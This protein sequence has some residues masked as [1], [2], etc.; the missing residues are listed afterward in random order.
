MLMDADLIKRVE[1]ITLT[2]YEPY[3]TKNENTK[4][5]INDNVIGMIEDLLLEIDRLDEQ[6]ENMREFYEEHY[7]YV[8]EPDPDVRR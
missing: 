2:D 4:L 8:P 1:E 5:V 7:Q 6:I 3:N